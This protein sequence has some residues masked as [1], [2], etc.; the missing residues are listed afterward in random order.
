MFART[1]F[2]I[3]FGIELYESVQYFASQCLRVVCYRESATRIQIVW[4]YFRP[5]FAGLSLFIHKPIVLSL[6]IF[7]GSKK[8]INRIM[9]SLSFVWLH[10]FFF[11]H[12]R[13][14][15]LTCY[16]LYANFNLN[17][18]KLCSKDIFRICYFDYIRNPNP[19]FFLGL[20]FVYL[21]KLSCENLHRWFMAQVLNMLTKLQWNYP[22]QSESTINIEQ[23]HNQT[24]MHCVD[25]V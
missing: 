20:N 14:F 22:H 24:S 7:V 23:L 16:S 10:S 25:W 11:N 5:R 15:R 6:W 1:C 17:S 21:C 12:F 3:Y 2:F 18:V 8:Y 13:I 9:K 4:W 19:G